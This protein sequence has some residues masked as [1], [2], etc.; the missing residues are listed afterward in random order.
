MLS[1][2]GNTLQVLALLSG[3]ASAAL[4]IAGVKLGPCGG[5]S[6]APVLRETPAPDASRA[7]VTPP[8]PR[9]LR[10][11]RAL[12]Y[13]TF[14]LLTAC[15]G[16]VLMAMLTENY[17]LAYVVS[18][19]P[20]TDSPLQPLYR[21]SAV[22]AG[23]Q[24][25]LLLWT[26]LISAFAAAQAFR[27]RTQ[28]DDLTSA[29]LGVAQIVVALFTATLVLSPSNDPFMATAAEYLNPDGTLAAKIGGMNP[30]LMHW[31]MILHP[32]A[33]FI[34]CAA[35]TIPF[36]YAMAALITGDLSARWVEL[37]DC[38]AVFGFIF[39][40]IGMGL[41]AVWAYVV[42]GWG[43]FWA[44]D[45]VENASLMSWLTCVA[46]IHSFTMYRKRGVF[47]R[48]S[49]L[50]ATATFI[51]VVLGTFI[52][53]SGLVQSVHAFAEDPVSTY[54]FLAIMVASGLAFLL[55]MLYR[56]SAFGED[57]EEAES[58]LSK[59]G[60]YYLTNIIMLMAAVLVAY[61]T[62]SSALP[63]WMPLGGSVVAAGAYNAVARPVAVA[64]VLLMAVCPMLGWR[65]TDRA[66]FARTM[67]VPAMA[68]M[69]VFALLMAYFATV[70][71]PEY[72]EILQA[73]GPA[74][75]ALSEQGPAAYYFALTIAAF[76]AAS[77]LFT[78]SLYL[79]VRGVGARMRNKG[80][81][82]P[83]ALFNL[84]RRS[85]AQAGG[86]L[87]HLGVAVVVVGLVGSMMYVREATLNLPNTVGESAQVGGYVLT[88][89]GSDRCADSQDNEIMR[90][91]LDVSN[92]ETGRKLGNVTPSMKV[93]AATSQSTLDAA[94]LTF[95]LEDLFI[96]FQGLN[97]DGTL[98]VSVKVNPL[99]LFTWVGG[100][101]STLG[102]VLAFAPRRAT[103]LLAADE[104][105][106]A[107]GA[108]RVAAQ[109]EERGSGVESGA[110]V[111]SQGV[112]SAGAAD[113]QGERA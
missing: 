48:W 33:T 80:E 81:S 63:G 42:L 73:G 79:L 91:E 39:L 4:L 18:N 17:S 56:H 45:A 5:G 105:E 40:S 6:A 107:R 78:S 35:M 100:A 38:L 88:L 87:C 59:N 12:V 25:S 29:A 11:G 54:F 1:I 74:A 43:G 41:G 34:G 14:F 23:R 106:R 37:C 30:L 32:P 69:A 31:A 51:F 10:A 46:M 58:M 62:I 82:A 7:T 3:L 83:T 103:P 90:V 68:G 49:M 70:L 61:L 67:R 65:K 47:K 60:T 21:V 55:G 85:P 66:K 13:A 93:A 53:R 102:I 89:T 112:S 113:S 36:A 86:Y 64:V 72:H 2:L 26:W 57:D 92:A 76:A 99:I 84:F 22:W 96:A 50:L 71:M 97:A 44:W 110:C 15:V 94:V 16:I 19:Y 108:E 52:T 77:L 75:D 95:P 28:G 20:A 8:S 111:E 101:V 109:A 98:S 24:G 27:R 9:A 104:R